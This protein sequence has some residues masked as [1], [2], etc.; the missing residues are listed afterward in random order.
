MSDEAARQSSHMGTSETVS[1]RKFSEIVLQKV[2]K[3][4][5]KTQLVHDVFNVPQSESVIQDYRCTLKKNNNSWGGRLFITQN[6]ML[7][8]SKDQQIRDSMAF[9]RVSGI[10]REKTTLVIPAIGVELDTG[11]VC[12]E[13]Q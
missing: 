6:Y 11:K 1:E 2:E 13:A 12:I 7:F 10:T 4:R 8:L 9:Y 5:E 3:M